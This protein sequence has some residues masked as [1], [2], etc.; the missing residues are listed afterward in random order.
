MPSRAREARG[1]EPLLPEQAI[2]LQD[3]VDA[4]TINAAF[5]LKTGA[6]DRQPGAG[7]AR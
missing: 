5:A 6:H 7:Q 1:R 2:T 3:V 4:Y